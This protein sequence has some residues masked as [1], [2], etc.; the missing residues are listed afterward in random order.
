MIYI[1]SSTKF[2]SYNFIYGSKKKLHSKRA[3]APEDR[4]EIF[5]FTRAPTSAVLFQIALTNKK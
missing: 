2:R 3:L 1:F 4:R 5:V